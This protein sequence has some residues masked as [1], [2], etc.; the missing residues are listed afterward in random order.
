M[1]RQRSPVAL[2]DMSAM[3]RLIDHFLDR[4]TMYRL[5]LYYLIF[6][7]VAAVALS[8]AGVL[9]YDPYALMFS[10]AFFVS[11]WCITNGIFAP[12][13]RVPDKRRSGRISVLILRPIF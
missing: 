7:V 1:V 5:F 8:F 4:I 2:K 10:T 3:I 9:P 11:V 6:L 13:F 12:A